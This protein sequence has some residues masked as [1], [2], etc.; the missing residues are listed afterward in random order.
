MLI[1]RCGNDL[2]LII[3]SK[4]GATQGDPLAMVMCGLGLLPLIRILKAE[5]PDLHQPW[6]ADD[7]GAGGRFQNIR[8]YFKKLQEYGP[9]RGY[10]PEPSK[11]ILIV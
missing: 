6:Y 1:I 11:S 2:F 4:E 5:V 3:L 10:F 8:L 7:A 9:P